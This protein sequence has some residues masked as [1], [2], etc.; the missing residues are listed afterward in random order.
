MPESKKMKIAFLG[1]PGILFR[2]IGFEKHAELNRLKKF[3]IVYCK[4][5]RYFGSNN[6]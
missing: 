4:G 6:I 5:L 1:N 2:L 3:I